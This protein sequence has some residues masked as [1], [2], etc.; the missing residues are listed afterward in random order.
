MSRGR[1]EVVEILPGGGT[2]D[3]RGGGGFVKEQATN[4]DIRYSP[5]E[6]KQRDAKKLYENQ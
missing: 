1:E 2:V 6:V 3:Y 4:V 5:A